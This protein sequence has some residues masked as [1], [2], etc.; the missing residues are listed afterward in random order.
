M[1]T[2]E[3]QQKWRDKHRPLKRQLNVMARRLIHDYLDEIAVR[4]RLDGKGEAVG[5]SAYVA[6][7]LMQQAEFNP[8]AA[9][10]L[11]LYRDSYARDRDLY[12]SSRRNADHDV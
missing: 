12:T 2:R 7:S 4:H 8:E 3:A 5:F 11:A 10:L 1:A 6:R 9:R